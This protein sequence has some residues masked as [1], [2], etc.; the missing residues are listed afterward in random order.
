MT[1]YLYKT[2]LM[3]YVCL[4]IT[5]TELICH[6]ALDYVIQYQGVKKS[7]RGKIKML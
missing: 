6:N 2:I 5:T 3:K 7:Q 1:R 4:N